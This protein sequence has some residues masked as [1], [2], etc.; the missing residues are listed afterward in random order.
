[1][2]YN[3][4]SFETSNYK[5]AITHTHTH[6]HTHTRSTREDAIKNDLEKLK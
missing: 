3:K 4:R 5:R 1:M 2:T 6:T